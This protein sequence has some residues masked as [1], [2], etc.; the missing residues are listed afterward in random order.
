MGKCLEADRPQLTVR[1]MRL[2]CWI[3]KATNIHREYVILLFPPQQWLHERS[4]VLTLCAYCCALF[5]VK[6]GGTYIIASHGAVSGSV[7]CCE[8]VWL[9]R[10][11]GGIDCVAALHNWRISL[12]RMFNFTKNNDEVNV[13]VWLFV[14]GG[15]WK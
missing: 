1:R 4:T 6:P 10:L 5:D 15:C 11:L 9:V 8:A 13:L 7:R 14:G 12:P 3:T 2:S